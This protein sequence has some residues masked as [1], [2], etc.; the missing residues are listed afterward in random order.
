MSVDLSQIPSLPQ[1][2]DSVSDQLRDL[3]AV[4]NRLGMHDAADAI[5][6]IFSKL[7]DFIKQ[8]RTDGKH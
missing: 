4:G 3:A 2:Q 5:E 6:Q 7:P 8:G 1:R